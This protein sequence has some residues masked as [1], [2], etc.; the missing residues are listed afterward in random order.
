MPMEPHADHMAS[1]ARFGDEASARIAAALL[2]SSGIATRIHGEALGPYKM[3]IGEMAVT[4][5]WVAE[6]DLDDAIEILTASE[7]EHTLNPAMRG[8]AVADP[9]N[10]P[11][12]VLAGVMAIILAAAVVRAL[13]RVF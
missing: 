9:G 12:R 13:M 4:D 2:E 1:L 7:I 11:M 8:G 6:G 10:L 3:T 5:I